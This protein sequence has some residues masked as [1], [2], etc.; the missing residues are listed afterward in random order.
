MEEII[1]IHV[2]K[3]IF[4]TISFIGFFMFIFT[5][6]SLLNGA[7]VNVH[8]SIIEL[9]NN[10]IKLPDG[11]YFLFLKRL[12]TSVVIMLIGLIGWMRSKES[13]ERKAKKLKRLL[14][15]E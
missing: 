7:M 4:I 3:V 15:L 11:V 12:L 10:S 13:I 2:R 1:R 14:E 8:K 9:S 6:C 5:I